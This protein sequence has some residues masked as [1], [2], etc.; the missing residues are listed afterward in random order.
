MVAKLLKTWD[1]SIE[2]SLK[3]WAKAEKTQEHIFFIGTKTRKDAVD[4]WD[5]SAIPIPNG[6][7]IIYDHTIEDLEKRLKKMENQL[8]E[9][10]SI[11]YEEPDQ[12]VLK[13]VSY[14]QAKKEIDEYFSKH[15]GE[16]FNAADI[17][18]ALNIDISLAIE[19]IGDLERE[20][21][22]KAG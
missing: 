19:I 21:K 16:I 10:N 7:K 9:L 15:H 3:G 12:I 14:E 4:M 1:D 18:E 20:G 5:A 17:Q 22:I 6:T 13:D 8:A 11:D 2:P